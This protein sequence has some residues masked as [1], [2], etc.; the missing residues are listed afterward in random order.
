MGALR[1]VVVGRWL[2]RWLLRGS[3]VAVVL[4]L[5]GVA[6]WGAWKW[7]RERRAEEARR[8][9]ER[10]ADYEIVPPGRL[11]APEPLAAGPGTPAGPAD[12]PGSAPGETSDRPA[13]PR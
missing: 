3:P 5:A 4:K 9:K 13:G 7:R 8:P 1:N 12:A 11:P 2:V 10:P 6:L